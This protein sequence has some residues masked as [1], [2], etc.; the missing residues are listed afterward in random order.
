MSE[1]RSTLPSWTEVRVLVPRGWHE[2]VADAL[3]AFP[4]TTVAVGNHSIAQEPP[5]EGFEALRTFVAAEDDT[6]ELR[7]GPRLRRPG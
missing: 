1:T 7:A 6:A 4:C 3:A 2:L 5:P